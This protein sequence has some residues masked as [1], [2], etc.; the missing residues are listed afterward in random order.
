VCVGF[1]KIMNQQKVL[2]LQKNFF[3]DM[4]IDASIIFDVGANVGDIT[5]EYSLLFPNSKIFCFEP[6]PNTFEGL[7]KRYENQ[8]N[9]QCYPY[10]VGENEK[11]VSIFETT[12]SANSS[13]LK[14]TKFISKSTEREMAES[15]AIKNTHQVKQI[16]LNS[17]CKK[18]KIQHIDLLKLDIQGTELQALE[19][20]SDLLD[21]QKIDIIY[22]EVQFANIYEGQCYYH[23]VASFLYKKNYKLFDLV[24]I[25][26]GKDGK[27]YYGD[28]IFL[29]PKFSANHQIFPGAEYQIEEQLEQK[30]AELKQNKELVE[31]K[32]D[33]IKSK[34]L[35]IKS[36]DLK[37]KSNE[38]KI[39]SKN[40]QLKLDKNE[41]KHLQET[42]R[43]EKDRID[44]IYHSKT[45]QLGQM[46]GKKLAGTPVEKVAEKSVNFILNRWSK[47]QVQSNESHNKQLK[48]LLKEHQ[49]VKGVIIYPPTVD[50]NIPLFQRPQHMAKHMADNN[51]LYFYCTS[52]TYDKVKKFSKI[53]K[54]FVFIR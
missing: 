23:D 30:E 9:I 15:V 48:K 18:N 39:K 34:E 32:E 11:D 52:N 36:K 5:K 47:N 4:K 50:W 40:R 37:I 33:E 27:I 20:V 16:T 6:I 1:D 21:E 43:G 25:V 38:D 41:I 31:Q 45:W 49:G 46:V 26:K 7:K 24:Y 29:S 51:W 35:K 13:L 12:D 42:V 19:G 22:T 2:E 54:K 53:Q 10:A 14:P 28:A 44:A 17:F 3:E 8:N